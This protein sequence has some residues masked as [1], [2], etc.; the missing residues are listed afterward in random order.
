M[1]VTVSPFVMFTKNTSLC[2]D[3]GILVKSPMTDF[4]HAI[5]TFNKHSDKKYHRDAIIVM[6]NFVKSIYL[7]NYTDLNSKTRYT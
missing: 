4:K 2:A 5:E 1:V 7:K 6:D 3:P